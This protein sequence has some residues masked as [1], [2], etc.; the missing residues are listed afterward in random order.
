MEQILGKNQT[1]SYRLYDHRP[2]CE[3]DGS[4]YCRAANAVLPE[5]FSICTDC[6]LCN[7]NYPD[8]DCRYFDLDDPY[9]RWAALHPTPEMEAQRIASCVNCG[10]TGEFPEFVE[11]DASE[12][13]LTVERAIRFAAV[14]HKGATRKGNHVPYIVHPI[15]TMMLVS[16][17][18]DDTDVIAAAALHDVVEDTDCTTDILRA[19]FGVR[20][21]ELVASESENKRDGEPKHD[22]W[23]IRKQENLMHVKE[24]PTE[25]KMIMLAD[26]VSNLRA[27]VRDF[28]K[29]GSDIWQKFN[30]KDEAQQAWYYKSVARVLKDLSYLKA[31]QEYLMMLEEVFEGVDTPQLMQ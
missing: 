13:Q 12:G 16:H 1:I 26:K 2:L 25:S 20:I 28:R 4:Y 11:E 15:E 24:A 18:T 21:A 22:T 27:T 10:Y 3:S 7:G 14:C 30:M 5:D 31:Y 9:D 8:N 23:K 29:S 17:M 19:E 6:P